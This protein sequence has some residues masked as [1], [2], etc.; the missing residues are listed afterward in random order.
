MAV[1]GRYIM[2]NPVGNPNIVEAGKATQFSKTNRPKKPG[3][4]PSKLKKWIKEN[5]VSNEDF[6]SIFVNIIAA[7]TIEELEKMIEG[8]N[9][10]KLPVIVM[11]CISAFIHDAKTGTLNSVNSILDRIMGRPAQQV[12][13]GSGG[14]MELPSDPKERRAMAEKLR[15]ELELGKMPSES[16]ISDAANKKE[17]NG[18]S[19]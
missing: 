8:D 17:K 4:K 15:R 16:D 10:K 7:H 6:I 19:V 1:Q 2:P 3:R 9:K 11:A 14:R 13:L 5:N 18:G 12:V